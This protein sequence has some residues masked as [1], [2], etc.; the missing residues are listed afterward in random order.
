MCFEDF[1]RV[2]PG[3]CFVRTRRPRTVARSD[4]ADTAPNS[5]PWHATSPEAAEPSETE[6]PLGLA[7][8]N[9]LPVGSERLGA[10]IDANETWHVNSRRHR[11]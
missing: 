1:V 10:A 2:F 11:T 9:F 6:S 4:Y 3:V 7:L 8:I 5:S